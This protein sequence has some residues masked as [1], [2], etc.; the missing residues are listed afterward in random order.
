[1]DFKG[2]RRAIISYCYIKRMWSRVLLFSFDKKE[3]ENKIAF[4]SP[5]LK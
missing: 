4:L 3:K 2:L 5:K 1:L